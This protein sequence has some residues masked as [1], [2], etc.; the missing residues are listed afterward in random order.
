[1]TKIVSTKIQVR[2]SDIDSMGHV[3]NAIYLNYFEYARIQYFNAL[4]GTEWDW[5]DQ[6]LLLANN[7]ID[8]LKPVLLTDDISIDTK[9]VKTGNKSFVLEYKLYVHKENEKVI[10]TQGTSTLVCYNYNLKKTIEIPEELKNEM[11]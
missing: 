11:I 6:G 1:M 3:N 10:Y 8:Y 5:F 2:F 7:N 4:I 9:C